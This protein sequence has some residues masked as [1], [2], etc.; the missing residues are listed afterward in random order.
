MW[1]ATDLECA[2]LSPLWYGGL[3][4]RAVYIALLASLSLAA[5]ILRG[6]VIRANTPLTSPACRR[7]LIGERRSFKFKVS[8]S[9]LN[10]KLIVNPPDLSQNSGG[11]H[12]RTKENRIRSTSNTES[13]SPNP[14]RLIRDHTGRQA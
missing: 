3:E 4:R 6:H 8:S 14:N 9:G 11:S 2:D 5:P 12:D 1:R 13:A 10:L 7:M